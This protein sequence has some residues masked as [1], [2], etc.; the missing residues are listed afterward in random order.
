VLSLVCAVAR[1]GII[2]RGGALPWHLPDD[3]AHFKR[4]TLGHPVIMGRRTW[5]SLP[6]ALPG[7]RNLVVTRTPGYRA[8]GAEVFESLEQALAACTA[9]DD[10]VVIGGAALYAAVLPRVQ[11]IYLTCVDADV[12]GDVHFPPWR[13]E[14][15][16]EVGRVEHPADARHAHAFSFVTLERR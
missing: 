10:P 14:D 12:E 15:F 7:R 4:I 1:N 11:R 5:E 6:R 2:G 9:S 8:A 3:L 16:R 13:R